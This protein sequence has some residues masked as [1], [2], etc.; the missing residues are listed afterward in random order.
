MSHMNRRSFLNG[1][2]IGA[3]AASLSPVAS[4]AAIGRSRHLIF[5]VN[6]GGARKKEYYE[7][8]SYAV[9]VR[10][11]AREGFVYEQD[12]CPC[13]ASHDVAFR[14][15]I[16][17]HESKPAHAM[18][19]TIMDYIGHG[20]QISSVSAI[21]EVLQRYQPR[22]IVCR[23]SDHDVAHGGYER[24]I[25]V[26]L[27]TDDAI[28]RVFDWVKGHPVFR[29]NTSIVIRPEFGRDDEVNDLGELH[30]SYGFYY[31]HRVASIFWGSQFNRGVDRTTVIQSVDMAPTLAKL[32]GV[33]AMFA[34]GRVA[35]GLFRT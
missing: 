6:G 11:I 13:V 26:I 34:E 31:T 14:E 33:N 18:A 21:P 16:Q 4:T 10:R 12:H 7:S 27:E 25:R 28:G 20:M 8:P 3:T 17:G 30:H 5:I 22:I 29:L 1:M 35:P 9:N 19:P 24:Y 23:Q 15:L 2:V 32:F